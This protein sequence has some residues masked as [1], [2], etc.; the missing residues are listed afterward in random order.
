MLH[1]LMGDEAFRAACALLLRGQPAAHVTEADLRR[2]VGAVH[3]A[4][5]DWFFDQW[6]HTTGTLDYRIGE[7]RP[8]SRMTV[9]GCAGGGDSGGRDLD[10]RGP[11]G[12]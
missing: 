2:A 11:A 8:G 7:L 1:W 6:I 9:A 10:A 4:G 12:G 5:L 3:P